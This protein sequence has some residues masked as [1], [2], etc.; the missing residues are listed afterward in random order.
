MPADSFA[1]EPQSTRE[2]LLGAGEERAAALAQGLPDIH[3]GNYTA[4]Y[5]AAV[6]A[7]LAAHHLTLSTKS[8]ASTATATA[9]TA[10]AEATEAENAATLAI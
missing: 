7:V 2:G 6:H 8:A 10:A 1:M 3:S 9:S 4:G 5:A